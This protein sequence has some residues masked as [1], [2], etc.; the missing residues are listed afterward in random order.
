M[1]NFDLQRFIDAQNYNNTYERA[2]QEIKNGNKE[3]HWIWYIFPQVCGLGHSDYSKRYGIRG[4][5]EARAYMKNEI[6]RKRLL[7]ICEALYELDTDD[8]LSV[9]WEID[10][11]KVRSCAT[12]FLRVAPECDVFGRLLDKYFRSIPCQKTLDILHEK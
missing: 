8:I 11:Y 4:Y 3:T 1:E 9:M 6:L 10:C 5:H 2:L 12:L 7:D